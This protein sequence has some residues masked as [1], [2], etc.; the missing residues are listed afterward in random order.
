MT[1]SANI[2]IIWTKTIYT[3]VNFHKFWNLFSV[4]WAYDSEKE[5]VFCINVGNEAY[6]AEGHCRSHVIEHQLRNL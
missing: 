1:N 4:I 6:K 3:K 2:E 5:H